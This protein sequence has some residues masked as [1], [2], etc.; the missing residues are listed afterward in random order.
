MLTTL[1]WAREKQ[2]DLTE[3]SI[4]ELMNV[5]VYAASKFEQKLSE[6]PSY[7]VLFISAS[8]DEQLPH[9]LKIVRKWHVLTVGDMKGFAQS[10]GI[11]NFT[12]VRGLI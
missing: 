1:C 5:T 2:V 8:E 4:E 12:I 11:I 6:A 7:H 9:I 3:L 10:G